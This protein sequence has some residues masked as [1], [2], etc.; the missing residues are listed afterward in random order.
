M[1]IEYTLTRKDYREFLQLTYKRIARI[2]KGNLKFFS[3]NLVAWIF[4]GMAFA[5]AVQFYDVYAWF[6]F[7]HLNSALIF[8]GIGFAWLVGISVYQR[9]FY[10]HYSIDNEGHL[11]QQHH[12]SITEDAIE[13]SSSMTRASYSWSAFQGRECSKNLVCLYIDNGQ[14]IIFPKRAFQGE[15][16]FEEFIALFDSKTK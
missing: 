14:A 2:G 3:L 16:Q 5:A 12:A 10:L 9:R 7:F 11:L 15:N 8:L 6:D 1:N 4:I 13:V